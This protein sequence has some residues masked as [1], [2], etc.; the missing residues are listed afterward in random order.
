[1]I[2]EDPASDVEFTVVKQTG[3]LD[4]LLND[5]SLGFDGHR[6]RSGHFCRLS[7]HVHGALL[8]LR[9]GH[10]LFGLLLEEFELAVL[11]AALLDDPFHFLHVVDHVDAAPR[12]IPV[13]FNIQMF[14][15]LP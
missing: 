5:E 4:V 7:W 1:M 14:F 6:G 3:P 11:H 8:L 10:L 2:N 13:G 9:E 12:F 15:P